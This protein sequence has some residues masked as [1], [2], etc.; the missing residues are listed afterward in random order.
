[1]RKWVLQY[2]NDRVSLINS[3]SEVSA[4]RKIRKK[5]YFVYFHSTWYNFLIVHF[6]RRFRLGTK[7]NH[8]GETEEPSVFRG[9]INPIDDAAV[10][11]VGTVI[12]VMLCALIGGFCE[13]R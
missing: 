5:T 6:A 4:V 9:H 10:T 11:W 12:T 2:P 8:V 13:T 7:C 3:V 1:M